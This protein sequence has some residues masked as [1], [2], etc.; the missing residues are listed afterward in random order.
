MKQIISQYEK[1][2]EEKFPKLHNVKKLWHH[3]YWDGPISGVCEYN[4]QKCWFEQIDEFHDKYSDYDDD[5]FSAPWYRRYLVHK[6]TDEQFHEILVRHQKWQRMVGTHCD[7][8]EEGKRASNFHYTD[9]ITKETVAQYYE[10]SKKDKFPDIT[11]VS[12]EYILGWFQ[13]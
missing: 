7:Y 11:P 3:G 4:G 6:L 13:W 8:D 1:I 2:Y 5:D 10:E 9:T 12:E